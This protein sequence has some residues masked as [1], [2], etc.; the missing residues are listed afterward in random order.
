MPAG[1]VTGRGAGARA[2]TVA[3]DHRARVH[4]ADGTT[5]T[6]DLVVA[7]DGMGSTVRRQLLPS[8]RI[9]PMGKFGAIGRTPLTDRFAALVP[10]WS[11]L[12]TTPT[13]Q[14]FLGKMPF[15]RPPD[16]AAAELAPDVALPAT[17]SYLRWVMMIPP[18]LPADLAA[19]EEDPDAALA[20]LTN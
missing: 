10:G 16:E 9:R 19:L 11:T 15:R 18:D 8:V 1:A 12:V 4:Y 7:A 5:E 20:L 6:A 14:L 13:L 3:L 2:A 17:P